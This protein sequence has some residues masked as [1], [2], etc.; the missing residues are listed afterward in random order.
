MRNFL[1]IFS[2]ACSSLWAV[3]GFFDVNKE[4]LNIDDVTS[5]IQIYSIF[6]SLV[7]GLFF[8][9]RLFKVT[10]EVSAIVMSLFSALALNYGPLKEHF[11]PILQSSYGAKVIF[12]FPYT[13]LFLC[14]LP[15]ITALVFKKDKYNL[16]KYFLVFVV[17][18]TVSSFYKGFN[19]YVEINNRI[20]KTKTSIAQIEQKN[21]DPLQKDN[22][23]MLPNVYFILLDA[24]ASE[25]TLKTYYNLENREFIN[26]LKN[27]GF[28]ISTKTLSNYN[29]TVCTLT[30]LLNMAYLPWT[31]GKLSQQ[32]VELQ[33]RFS[34]A[35]KELKGMGYTIILSV[36][37][38]QMG[39]G[40]SGDMYTLPL[41]A[42]TATQ[43]KLPHSYVLESKIESK[44]MGFS[45]AGLSFLSLTPLIDIL[46]DQGALI[47]AD[48]SELEDIDQLFAVK[49]ISP[50]PYIYFAHILLPHL[51]GRYDK[52]C[53]PKLRSQLLK[54]T[55]NSDDLTQE[56]II[57]DYKD[58]LLCLNQKFNAVVDKITTQDPN[59]IIIV[60]ADHGVKYHF[61]KEKSPYNSNLALAY[62]F[63]PEIADSNNINALD[64]DFIKISDLKTSV[65]MLYGILSGYRLPNGAVDSEWYDGMSPVNY[66]RWLLRKLGKK[67]IKLL[68][69]KVFIGDVDFG[70][71]YDLTPH[72]QKEN[73]LKD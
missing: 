6:L 1:F 73:Q 45:N 71:F 51:P 15:L 42:N 11:I 72:I 67:D 28:N 25:D 40:K 50:K 63:F 65:R 27:K 69:D 16:F 39:I 33:G 19:S 68:E 9:L 62:K 60:T 46:T 35:F 55:F 54:K 37:G 13:F 56:Q 36:L 14:I 64:K 31:P 34:P 29:N 66:F 32:K 10:G 52:N 38:A 7:I 41:N 47:E 18:F 53:K 3:L 4:L 24:Y 5:I 2:I 61:T 22:K 43:E 8:I 20:Q 70:Y 12:Y 57:E 17:V 58:N 21:F 30:S 49:S 48:Y 44:Y 23:E 26:T 59:S